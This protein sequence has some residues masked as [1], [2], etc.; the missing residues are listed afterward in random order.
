MK[1]ALLTAVSGLPAELQLHSCWGHGPSGAHVLW[2]AP[3]QALPYAGCPLVEVILAALAFHRGIA[4]TLDN[5]AHCQASP[6][7]P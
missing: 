6:L 4:Q 5:P 1:A 2:V 3:L 7:S